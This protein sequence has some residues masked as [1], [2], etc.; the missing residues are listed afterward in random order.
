MAQP[1]ETALTQEREDGGQSCAL[2]H[3]RV[4]DLVYVLPSYAEYASKAAQMETIQFLLL[5]SV[6]CPSLSP[7]LTLW[8]IQPDIHKQERLLLAALI[9]MFSSNKY[10]RSILPLVL[11]YSDVTACCWRKPSLVAQVYSGSANKNIVVS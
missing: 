3:V 7:A 11:W 2:E 10:D 9:Y 1:A 5:G 8:K 6:C 4:G